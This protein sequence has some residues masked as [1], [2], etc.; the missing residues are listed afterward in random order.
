MLVAALPAATDGL[1]FPHLPRWET[2][3]A[4]FATAG[5]AHR[6]ELGRFAHFHSFR[7]SFETLGVNAGQPAKC[8]AAARSFRPMIDR[9]RLYRCCLP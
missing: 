1:V 3:R 9:W 2:M 5:I 4:D 7:K 6:D 8:A